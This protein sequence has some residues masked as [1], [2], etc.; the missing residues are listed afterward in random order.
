[1]PVSFRKNDHNGFNLYCS[2]KCHQEDK[3]RKK[4]I[5]NHPLLSD[6]NWLC[7][8]RIIKRKSKEQIAN[9]LGISITPI[10]EA[11]KLHNIEELKLNE[12]DES[13]LSYLKNKEWLIEKHVT[14]HLTLSEIANELGSTKAT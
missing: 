6:E 5:H 14:N 10:N 12:S 8:E 9:E 7:Q 4:I 3:K 13:I 11:I 2:E 1:N